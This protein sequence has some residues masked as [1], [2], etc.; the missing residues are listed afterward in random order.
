MRFP[1]LR[2]WKL[3]PADETGIARACR[4]HAANRSRDGR[5]ARAEGVLGD[6]F[7]EPVC[8][9]IPWDHFERM[10]K[11]R[12][13]ALAFLAV[14]P[15]PGRFGGSTVLSLRGER[16]R[17]R[18]M[19]ASGYLVSKQESVPMKISNRDRIRLLGGAVAYAGLSMAR[20]SRRRRVCLAG[21]CASQAQGVEG[22]ADAGTAEPRHRLQQRGDG[23]ADL[24]QDDG[25]PGILRPRT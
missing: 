7:F 13:L 12:R 1:Q 15:S 25:R 21:A 5:R 22:G 19:I 8:G 17:G 3:L 23:A 9:A 20:D 24:A 6:V 14:K 10:F 16:G 18:E 11:S 4:A 2:R